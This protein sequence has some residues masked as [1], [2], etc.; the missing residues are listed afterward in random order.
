MDDTKSSG[1]ENKSPKV[2]FGEA[3]P[4]LPEGELEGMTQRF[5]NFVRANLQRRRGLHGRL[6]EY[7][8]DRGNERG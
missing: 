3:P 4:P 8:R 1:E 6:A 2:N 5:T 7:D